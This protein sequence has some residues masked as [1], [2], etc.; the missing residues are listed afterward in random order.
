MNSALVHSYKAELF[1]LTKVAWKSL[2][3]RRWGH[4]PDNGQNRNL[5]LT[6]ENSSERKRMFLQ[7]PLGVWN[8]SLSYLW[9]Q[10]R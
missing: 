4:E 8:L 10:L 7:F 5:Y 3:V 9:L 6:T 2:G 1:N